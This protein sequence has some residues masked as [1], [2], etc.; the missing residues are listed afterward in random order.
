MPPETST[1]QFADLYEE[2]R[3]N[4]QSST[5]GLTWAK[6]LAE[7]PF[8]GQHWEGVYGLPPGSIKPDEDWDP[9]SDTSHSSTPSLSPWDDDDESEQGAASPICSHTGSAA[10]SPSPAEFLLTEDTPYWESRST[11]YNYRYEVEDLQARQYWKAGWHMDVPATSS[12][13]MG[14]PSTLGLSCLDTGNV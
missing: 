12:F 5:S 10:G 6:I 13:S 3:R 9:A 1:L 8:K 7:E 11:R 4:P 14:D 2:H